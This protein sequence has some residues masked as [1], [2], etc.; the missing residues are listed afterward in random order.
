MSIP[1]LRLA[2]RPLANPFPRWL[3]LHPRLLAIMALF[4]AN[5]IWAGSAVAS[6]ATLAHVQPLTMTSAR[7]G[8]SCG[9][10]SPITTR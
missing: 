5:V 10:R 3:A 2:D 9:K 6:K 1:A 4:G 7:G 8:P